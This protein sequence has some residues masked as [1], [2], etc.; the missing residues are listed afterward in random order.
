MTIASEL[1]VALHAEQLRAYLNQERVVPVSLEM[2]ITSRCNKGCHNCPSTLSAFQ[3]D[4]PF[5]VVKNLFSQLKGHTKGLLISGGEPTLSPIFTA[6]LA[7]ARA[8]AFEHIAVVSNGTLLGSKNI[9]D[10]LIRHAS[11]LRIS[12][13]GWDEIPDTA[14]QQVFEN[15]GILRNEI[16]RNR[17]TLEIGMS[18][19]TDRSNAAQIKHVA[20][21]VRDAGAHWLYCHPRC[22]GW[23]EESLVQLDQDGVVP[24]L[25]SSNG[26]LNGFQLHYFPHRYRRETLQFSRYHSGHFLMVLGADCNMYLGTETKYNPKHIIGRVDENWQLDDLFDDGRLQALNGM[27]SQCY[28]P[29]GGRHRG[30]LYND[31]I[32][33]LVCRELSLEELN[34]R[35]HG[36]GLKFANI[37]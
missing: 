2:D 24:S 35:A 12:I 36:M 26:R 27:G 23:D 18:F 6:T 33:R 13:Y 25:E 11:V 29:I 37:L 10:A 7:E 32:E 3:H 8:N 15:I 5:P 9:R 1:K 21:A 17:S 31:L 20:H 4:M 19:L 28:F 16:E 30:C 34:S 14:L 22:E